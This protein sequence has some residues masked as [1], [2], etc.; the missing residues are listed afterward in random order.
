V[1]DFSQAQAPEE[2][3]CA[4]EEAGI[5]DPFSSSVEARVLTGTAARQCHKIPY[6]S[7]HFLENFGFGTYLL[8]HQR[9]SRFVPVF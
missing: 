3:Q 7:L 8:C 5:A 4:M 9:H 6:K 2:S 1:A